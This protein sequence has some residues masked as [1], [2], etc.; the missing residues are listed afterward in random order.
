MNK[1]VVLFFLVVSFV[2][3][4]TAFAY[5]VHTHQD[6]AH[7][8]IEASELQ[9]EEALLPSLGLKPFSHNQFFSNSTFPG[10]VGTLGDLIEHGV[11]QEDNLRGSRFLHHFYDPYHHVPLT[12]VSPTEIIG[13]AILFG[14]P[15]LPT[16][17]SFDWALEDSRDLGGD[18][19]FSFKDARRYFFEGLSGTGP[20]GNSA[21]VRAQN[22]GR[23]FQTLGHVIHHI[24]DMA[25]PQ[26]VKNEPHPP[27]VRGGLYEHYTDEDDIRER[28]PFSGYEPVFSLAPDGDHSTF[29][30]PHRLWETGDGKGLAEFTN[31]NFVT[32][33]HNFTGSLTNILSNP[34]FP[35]PHGAD[36][37]IVSEDVHIVPQV[38]ID[39]NIP[40][41]LVGKIYYIRAP[42]TDKYRGNQ[43]GFNNRAS[44]FSIYDV[45]LQQ[46]HLTVPSCTGIPTP[47]QTEAVF[48]VNRATMRAAHAFLIPR[49]VG[50]SAGLIN[51]FFRGAGK[52]DLVPSPQDP[53]K[54]VL[55][56][57]GEEPLIGTFYLF[58]DDQYDNRWLHQTW[59]VNGGI[60]AHGQVA[61]AGFSPPNDPNHLPKTPG[62]YLLVFRGK[63][64]QEGDDPSVAN[65][66]PN[67]A[68]AAN[69]VNLGNGGLIVT[70]G[71]DAR[72]FAAPGAGGAV[73]IETGT[74]LNPLPPATEALEVRDGETQT[75]SGSGLKHYSRITIRGTLNLIGDTTLRA[76]GP[77]MISGM[78]DAQSATNLQDGA[79]LTIE[80]PDIIF[81]AG[82]IDT[83]GLDADRTGSGP[84]TGGIG[85][86]VTIRTASPATFAVPTIITR[87]GDAALTDPRYPEQNFVGASGGAVTITTSPYAPVTKKV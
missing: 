29:S 79:K 22:F 26:H 4:Q 32:D 59:T 72:D 52:I 81:V 69:M 62:Q 12:T 20:F 42:V 40:A 57:N 61:V 66:N 54:Y 8:A 23:T 2:G 45:D 67:F 31:F 63:M 53:D 86:S 58:Y 75:L 5:E 46:F 51:Y 44:T 85:G 37:Q 71:G 6:I 77:V 80:S 18:Q 36:A 82:R 14:H 48:S 83:S 76:D 17:K 16:Q 78:I 27:H 19:V 9:T 49:A 10:G 3:S 34:E 7:K 55:Q 39:N 68:V 65:N 84:P 11:E 87:G 38:S 50:Y 30:I 33:G 21:A 64:G 1:L 43:S 47:C 56:N 28:L 15:L 25:Q 70:S 35:N 60:A 13:L 74:S 41:E 73:T 24:Q